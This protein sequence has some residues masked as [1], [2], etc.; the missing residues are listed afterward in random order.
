M[1]SGLA[2]LVNRRLDVGQIVYAFLI[3]QAQPLS[4]IQAPLVVLRLIRAIG[5]YS[6]SLYFS[7]LEQHLKRG[8]VFTLEALRAFQ[9]ILKTNRFK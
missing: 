7:F 5:C 9:R 2:G 3:T 8:K 4:S 6:I 1:L